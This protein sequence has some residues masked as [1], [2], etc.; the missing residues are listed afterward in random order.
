MNEVMGDLHAIENPGGRLETQ[1]CTRTNFETARFAQRKEPK[2]IPGKIFEILVSL[3]VE[4]GFVR[5]ETV[6]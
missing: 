2:I 5:H 3:P 4:M 6:R 1:D